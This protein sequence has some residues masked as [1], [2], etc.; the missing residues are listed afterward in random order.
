MK[1]LTGDFEVQG[2]VRKAVQ[3]R[4]ENDPTGPDHVFTSGKHEGK[5][6]KEIVGE[7]QDYA[8]WVLNHLD[9]RPKVK[10]AFLITL[11]QFQEG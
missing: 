2:A 6:I 5:T 8:F 11:R 3:V 9:K 4:E 7:N 10:H 1:N